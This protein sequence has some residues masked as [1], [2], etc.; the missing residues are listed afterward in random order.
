VELEQI[1]QG[2]GRWGININ[3][4]TL[5]TTAIKQVNK[6]TIFTREHKKAWEDLEDDER[7]W[8][9]FKTHFI[10]KI[11]MPRTPPAEEDYRALTK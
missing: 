8:E 9:L 11:N 7:D 3:K 10:E 6:C 1:K 4:D 5:I 2:L